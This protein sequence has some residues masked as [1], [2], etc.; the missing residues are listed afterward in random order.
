MVK[1]LARILLCSWENYSSEKNSFMAYLETEVLGD[2]LIVVSI[3]AENGFS[4]SE[5]G[6]L[7]FRCERYRERSTSLFVAIKRE[8]MNVMLIISLRFPPS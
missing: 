6:L 2:P 7:K 1:M 5:L 4:L 3:A 8:I